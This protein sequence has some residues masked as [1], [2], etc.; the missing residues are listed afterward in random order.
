MFTGE[1]KFDL[2]DAMDRRLQHSH[3]EYY[4]T[5]HTTNE[6]I[7]HWRPLTPIKHPRV[8]TVAAS[9]DQALMY[10]ATGASRVD[11]FDISV[12]ACV[13]MDFK[14]SAL[15]FMNYSQYMQSVQELY[16]PGTMKFT[17]P[18]IRT[19][20]NM[21]LRT[22]TLIRNATIHR[23]DAFSKF[24]TDKPEYPATLQKYEKIQASVHT[25]FNFIWADLE[26]VSH[27]ITGQ[28]DIIN[29]SNIFDHFLWYKGTPDTIYKTIRDLWPHLNIGGYI[30]CTTLHLSATP[31]LANIP[32]RLPDLDVTVSFPILKNSPWWSPIV[33]Q[34]TR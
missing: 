20:D 17:A 5:Y 14:T 13:A 30:L 32:Q 24:P 26:N 10:A 1:F 29:V 7:E 34:K 33:I 9:G 23:H 25:P 28:Y 12:F 8:L 18:I 3:P 27:Y 11:T 15:Q 19:V 21:P 2:N 4:G 31:F 6:P 16:N 22:R